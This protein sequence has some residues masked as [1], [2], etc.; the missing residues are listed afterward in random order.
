M[1]KTG[2]MTDASTIPASHLDL[3]QNAKVA[4]F[5]TIGPSGYP[6]TGAIWFSL[7]DGTIRTSQLPIRQRVKNVL[8]N[9]KASLFI[10][11]PEDPM[12][13]VDIRGDVTVEDD[14]DLSYLGRMLA[15]Y[16]QTVDDF[17]PPKEGRVVVTIHPTRVRVTGRG[18]GI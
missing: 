8:A 15:R 12:A 4:A 11:D 13:T 2:R 16:G 17:Q 14:A 18:A 10:I 1:R 5:T 7:E 3:V 9:P 6:Q